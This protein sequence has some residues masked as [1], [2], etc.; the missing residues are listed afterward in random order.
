MQ[1]NTKS[2]KI[3]I[4]AIQLV[5]LLILVGMMFVR[6]RHADTTPID[7]SG[8]KSEASNMVFDGQSWYVDLNAVLENE[9][10]VRLIYTPAKK[11]RAG[12]YTAVIDYTSTEL[13]K[14]E[15][16]SK[17]AEI[18]AADFFILSNNKKQVSYDFTLGT[19]AKELKLWLKDY[20]RGDFELT[21]LTIRKNTNDIRQR[22]IIWLIISLAI[23]ILLFNEKNYYRLYI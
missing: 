7:I 23:D 16:I 15:I 13:Q 3:A 1:P 8:L 10:D 21:G 14:A 20:Y 19:S 22:I 17:G 4:V 11:L 12:T 2:K 18:D 9:E 5:V 6:S